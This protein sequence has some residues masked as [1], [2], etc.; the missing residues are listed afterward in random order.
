MEVH[1]HGFCIDFITDE[2]VIMVPVELEQEDYIKS[3]DVYAFVSVLYTAKE[4]IEELEK[5]YENFASSIFEEYESKDSKFS[6]YYLFGEPIPQLKKYKSLIQKN[7]TPSDELA[8]VKN[9][10]IEE[11]RKAKEVLDKIKF[12]F[13]WNDNC[14]YFITGKF[15]HSLLKLQYEIQRR[16]CNFECCVEELQCMKESIDE[17][18]EELG[19]KFD[20]SD[21]S[22]SDD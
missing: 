5:L 19:I 22:D 12:K 10:I 18:I 8:S 1:R 15:N 7:D 13:T 3:G 21:D 2:R 20:D 17:C 16:K 14:K 6:D 9:E 4:Y 11:I